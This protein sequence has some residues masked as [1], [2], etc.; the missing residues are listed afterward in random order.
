M[1]FCSCP[2]AKCWNA[3]H[4]DAEF[5]HA[6][7]RQVECRHAECHHDECR[8]APETATSNPIFTLQVHPSKKLQKEMFSK[9]K[10]LADVNDKK[11]SSD[12]LEK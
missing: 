10:S 4:H 3:E 8:G 6:E 11:P 9:K 1:S 12:A 7:C 5:H 2:F